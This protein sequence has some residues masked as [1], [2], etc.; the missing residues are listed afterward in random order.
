[1]PTKLGS[2]QST[3]ATSYGK[4]AIMAGE[5]HW[6]AE[7][8][9]TIAQAL[10][11]GNSPLMRRLIGR[12]LDTR[13]SGYA[14][15]NGH[16]PAQVIYTELQR[17]GDES[18]LSLRHAI[19]AAL[20]VLGQMMTGKPTDDAAGKLRA[21]AATMRPLDSEPAPDNRRAS[22]KPPKQWLFNFAEILD[23]VGMKANPENQRRIKQLNTSYNG[24]IIFGQKGQP[25]KCDKARLL[26]WWDNL[27]VEFTKSEHKPAS[28]QAV[29]EETYCYGR[30][31]KVAPVIGGSI[32][33]RKV[34]K[35]AK[36]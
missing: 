26:E 19:N 9:E 17:A 34:P 27:E 3:P 6:H 24:P 11:A 5:L 14:I 8:L 25:P 13:P 30:T 1:M 20:V 33:K 32:R 36:R 23:A 15:S 22:D 4:D 10:E 12:Y 16:R 2:C 18:T 31:G 21:A 7:Q 28:L 29:G 35:G